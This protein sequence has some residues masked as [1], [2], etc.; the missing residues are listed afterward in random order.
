MNLE[1]TGVRDSQAREKDDEL[2]VE[3]A[4]A[5]GVTEASNTEAVI[6]FCFEFYLRR[7]DENLA[8]LKPRVE[9]EDSLHSLQADLEEKL[10]E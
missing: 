9:S 8:W 2:L 5:E 4:E 6:E 7:S 10:S 3:V 1:E